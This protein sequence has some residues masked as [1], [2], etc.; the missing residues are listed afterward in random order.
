MHATL[1][2]LSVSWWIP[3][4]Y[5]RRVTGLWWTVGGVHFQKSWKR[6]GFGSPFCRT[7]HFQNHLQMPLL[8]GAPGATFWCVFLLV[9]I[10]ISVAFENPEIKW[11]IIFEN[12]FLMLLHKDKI[13]IQAFVLL[14]LVSSENT[15]WVII[16]KHCSFHSSFFFPVCLSFRDPIARLLEKSAKILEFGPGQHDSV[17]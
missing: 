13:V 1:L 7:L 4:L 11:N 10:P 15:I 6:T 16:R 3:S 8:W 5:V 2:E 9:N 17:G 12:C 14:T